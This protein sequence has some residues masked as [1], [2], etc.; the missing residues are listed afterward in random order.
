MQPP[1]MICP[2]HAFPISSLSMVLLWKCTVKL[3]VTQ[4]V[5]SDNIGS[6]MFLFHVYTLGKLESMHPSRS[7]AEHKQLPDILL[8]EGRSK[9]PPQNPRDSH[10]WDLSTTSKL[11][12]EMKWRRQKRDSP[13]HLQKIGK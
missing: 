7:G 12:L 3:V 13:L 9:K 6:S 5:L 11:K 1:A 8:P 10:S 4:L 2:H